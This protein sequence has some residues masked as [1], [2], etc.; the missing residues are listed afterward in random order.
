MSLP[1]LT[2]PSRRRGLQID[3]F[4]QFGTSP[5]IPL[6]RFQLFDIDFQISL[7]RLHVV[8]EGFQACWRDAAKRAGTLAP[9]RLLYLYVA[10]RREF[11]NLH[12]QVARRSSWSI[13]FV[14]LEQCSCDAVSMLQ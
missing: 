8:L 14:M 6:A 7:Q 4:L 3:S 9:E 13:G 5:F 11:V 2:P 12:T 1:P 10:R